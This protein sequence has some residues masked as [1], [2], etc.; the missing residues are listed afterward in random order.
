MEIWNKLST[1]MSF[2]LLALKEDLAHRKRLNDFQASHHREDDQDLEASG[3]EGC[4]RPTF[5]PLFSEGL[6]QNVNG[7]IIPIKGP[8][9]S[10]LY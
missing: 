5:H 3:C 10:C 7:I 4:R 9:F 1:T 6:F 2:P 8:I